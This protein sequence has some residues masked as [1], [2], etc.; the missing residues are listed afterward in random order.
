MS[1]KSREA[2]NK[3]CKVDSGWHCGGKVFFL[4]I[5]REII[6]SF[7]LYV[8]DGLDVS[9]KFYRLYRRRNPETS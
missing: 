3:P 9:Y 4:L 2:S 8:G 7:L 1:L 6:S 5:K